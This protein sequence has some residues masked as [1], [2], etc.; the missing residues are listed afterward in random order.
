MF[1]YIKRLFGEKKENQTVAEPA[2]V[3]A[4][5]PVVEPTPAVVVPKEPS[6]TENGVERLIGKIADV[7]MKTVEAETERVKVEAEEFFAAGMHLKPGALNAFRGQLRERC[8]RRYRQAVDVFTAAQSEVAHACW[9]QAMAK[10]DAS[11]IVQSL[12]WLCILLRNAFMDRYP[13]TDLLHSDFLEHVFGELRKVE[14]AWKECFTAPV[15]A[16][17][18]RGIRILKGDYGECNDCIGYDDAFH[19]FVLFRPDDNYYHWGGY[20][21]YLI[22]RER[23]EE[24]LG[25]RLPEFPDPLDEE[26]AKQYYKVTSKDDIERRVITKKDSPDENEI[27]YTSLD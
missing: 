8:I 17:T 25:R 27:G 2:P 19:V 5:V 14:S 15:E 22:S 1:D 9:Q 20:H 21:I 16:D 18:R 11:R 24:K 6:M 13:E 12:D 4:P 10:A 26:A 7:M 3:E 23:A